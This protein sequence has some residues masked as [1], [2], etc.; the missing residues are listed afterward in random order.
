MKCPSCGEQNSHRV[1]DSRGTEGN[2]AIRRR[3]VCEK[4]DR[5]F[6]TKERIEEEI[7]ISVIKRDKSRVPYR[8]D[9]IEN[10]IRHACYKVDI[11]DAEIAQ[12]VDGIEEEL[13]R[14]HDR[15]VASSE[16]GQI[17]SKHL[18]KLNAVAYVRFMSVYR[19]YN[20]VTEFVEEIQ[21]VKARAASDLPEQQSLFTE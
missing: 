7:R 11:N 12:V 15:D 1:I 2:S 3:R 18:R 8:R 4:C 19:K 14:E 13:F 17:V 5:R 20:D 6:T 21:D 9:K 10:G 16:I